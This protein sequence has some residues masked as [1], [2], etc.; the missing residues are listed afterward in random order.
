M[1]ISLISSQMCITKTVQCTAWW[2]CAKLQTNIQLWCPARM[3]RF[4]TIRA[5]LKSEVNIPYRSKYSH[6]SPR[7]TVPWI[8]VHWAQWLWNKMN[9]ILQTTFSNSCFQRKL[10]YFDTLWDF[11][12]DLHFNPISQAPL[13]FAIYK[14]VKITP[15]LHTPEWISNYI[16]YKVRDEF[17]YPPQTSTAALLKF[18]NG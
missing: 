3:T 17:N 15:T 10:L 5:S 16:H 12:W 1:T 8:H 18:G 11:Q 6:L 4:D 9:D 7:S 14:P 13:S 2:W